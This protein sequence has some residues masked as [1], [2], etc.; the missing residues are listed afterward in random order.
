MN[1]SWNLQQEVV[2]AS[3]DF[4]LGSGAA[5]TIAQECCEMRTSNLVLSALLAS[6][7]AMPI[8]MAQTAGGGGGADGRW[9]GR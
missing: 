9:R 1:C 7:V 5:E 2:L 6:V 3:Q 8:A 4:R